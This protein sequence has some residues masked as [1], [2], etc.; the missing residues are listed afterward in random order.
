MAAK[1][2]MMR[3]VAAQDDVDSVIVARKCL[4]YARSYTVT[5]R[6]VL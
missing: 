1:Q 6:N 3:H 4:W 5:R 2:V